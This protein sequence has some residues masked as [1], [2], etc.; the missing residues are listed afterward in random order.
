MV[1]LLP[2]SVPKAIFIVPVYLFFAQQDFAVLSKL[3]D[4]SLEFGFNTK[5]HLLLIVLIIEYELVSFLFLGLQI[6]L[7]LHPL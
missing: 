1:S 6:C 5:D 2:S 3:L 4:G 7:Q